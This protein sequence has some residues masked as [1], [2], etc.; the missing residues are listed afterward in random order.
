MN[1]RWWNHL[2]WRAIN[3]NDR[4]SSKGYGN[5]SPRICYKGGQST[6]VKMNKV[7]V[8]C[9]KNNK[10]I[11]IYY[12]LSKD[13]KEIEKYLLKNIKTKCNKQNNK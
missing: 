8:S 5:I 2:Y 3:L 1:S 10:I 6:N 13:H 12:L 9:F 11:K 4:F 7:V